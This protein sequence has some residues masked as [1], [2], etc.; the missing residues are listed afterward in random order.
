MTVMMTTNTGLRRPLPVIADLRESMRGPLLSPGDEGYET[1]RQIWNAMID[2][3]PALIACCQN[4]EDVI[5]AVRFAAGHDMLTSVRG[6]GHNIAGSAVCDDG[7][8]I[9]LSEMREVRVD[10][11]RRRVTVQGGA[12]LADVDRET[13]AFGLAVPLGINSTTGIGGL[14]LGGGFGWLSR[15]FGHTVDNLVGAEIVTATGELLHLGPSENADLFWAIRGGGGNFGVVVSFE[16]RLHPVGP[17]VLSGPVIHALEDA[18]MVLRAFRDAAPRMSDEASCWTVLRKA[19]PFPFLRQEHHGREVLILAMTYAGAIGAGEA[20]LA[21][22]RAIG[23]PLADAISPH[24]YAGW[25]AA[26]DP[27]LAPRARNYWKSHDFNELSD[28]MIELMTEA[29]AT[30][31]TG[32]CEIF[33]AQLGGAAGRVAEASTAYAHRRTKFTM[34]IHGRWQDAG[35]DRECLAWVRGLFDRAAPFALGSVYINF[36]PEAHEN[37]T[38]GAFGANEPRL[39]QIKLR[40]DPAN[41]FRSNVTLGPVIE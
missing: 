10:A 21:P 36:V 37:R 22:L 26:F 35:Q 30:L 39:R 38:I 25:Q 11:S 18:P 40:V 2:R 6:G 7:L 5:A 4:T 1:K 15:A 29:A 14:A 31:P 34:N 41:L 27:L 8:M 3:R 23:A 12:I 33:T 16:F 13:Q 9:D 28:E 19:P 32:E 24:P 17:M 20:A